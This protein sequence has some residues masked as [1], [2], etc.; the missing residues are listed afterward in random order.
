M[1]LTNL[2]AEKYTF[3]LPLHLLGDGVEAPVV[4]GHETLDMG[5]AISRRNLQVCNRIVNCLVKIIMTVVIIFS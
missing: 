1:T 4:A 2:L 3:R 5:G